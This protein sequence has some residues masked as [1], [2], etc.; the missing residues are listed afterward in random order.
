MEDSAIPMGLDY[1]TTSSYTAV[2]VTVLALE[3]ILNVDLPVRATGD[4]LVEI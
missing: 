2:P 1:S 3:P 4:D